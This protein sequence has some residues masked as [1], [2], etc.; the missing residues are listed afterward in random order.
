MSVSPTRL[1]HA[2]LFVAD[3]DRSVDFYAK[4]FG[5]DV[6]V[7]ELRANAAFLRLPKSGNHQNLGLFGVGT[8]T[9]PRRRG[10]LGLYHLA[11]QLDT[12]NELAEARAVLLEAKALTGESDHDETKS[13]D[14]SDPDG[15]EFELLWMV[16]RDEWGEN[17]D[18][19]P[20]RRLDL[21]AEIGRWHNVRTA[22][23]LVAA[24]DTARS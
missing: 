4:V 13:L 23:E 10:E 19:A 9:T 3:L 18:A 14:G 6:I 7:R 12:I 2:V 24:G 5:M 22:G 20:A 21:E 15:N 8:A 1:S 11:R 16:P 17:S